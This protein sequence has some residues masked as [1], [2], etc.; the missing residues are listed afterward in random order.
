MQ[1]LSAVTQDHLAEAVAPV[2]NLAE[3][4]GI[5]VVCCFVVL[6]ILSAYV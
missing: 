4:N 1:A 6:S 5:I 3:A 2:N